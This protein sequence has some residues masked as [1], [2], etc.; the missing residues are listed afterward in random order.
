MRKARIKAE[1]GIGCYHVTS[2]IVDRS[3][4]M[5]EDEREI[6]RHIL[7]KAE[8]FSGVRVLTYAILSNH[9]HIL[10]DVPVQPILDD[11]ELLRRIWALYG[12]L[13]AE[14][15]KE[16]WEDW[17]KG[18]LCQFV[19]REQE[20][21]RRRMGDISPF[22]KLL[23]QCY[24]ISYNQRHAR[25]GTLWEGRYASL[26]VEGESRALSTV[27]AYI[28][29]NPVRAGIVRDPAEYRWSGYGEACG[30]SSPARQGILALQS[31]GKQA[32]KTDRAEA[33]ATYRASLYTHGEERRD[34]AGRLQRVGFSPEEARDVIERGGRMPLPDLL[35]CRVR[36]FRDGLAFGSKAFVESV[37]ERNRAHFG[38]KRK[39]G[40]RRMRFCLDGGFFTVRDLRVEPVT[41]SLLA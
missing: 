34:E 39:T 5:G 36:Y 10:L 30:G 35:R 25:T 3:F 9:F 4:K 13:E 16:R 11:A 19:E 29:L 24:S 2:R 12:S 22:M 27:A 33:M 17:R 37:F 21:L 40:A 26:L 20:G 1:A 23:K 31:F 32:Q 41:V 38:A 14:R 15:Y 8:V 18:G 28:D 7:R 6:F